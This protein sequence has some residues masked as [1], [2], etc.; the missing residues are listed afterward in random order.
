MTTLWMDKLYAKM[1][2]SIKIYKIF[3]NNPATSIAY[4]KIFIL[5]SSS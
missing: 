5:Y 1:R 2:N 4:N 3:F